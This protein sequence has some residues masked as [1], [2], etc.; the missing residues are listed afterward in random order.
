DQPG[1]KVAPDK[2]AQSRIEEMLKNATPEQKKA[3]DE[4][5]AAKLSSV[6]QGGDLQELR[7]FVATFGVQLSAGQEARLLL[8]ER[9]TS[10]NDPKLLLEVE[11]C[12]L[13]LHAIDNRQLAGQAVEALARHYARRGLLEDAASKYRT[14]GRDFAHIVI[15]DGKTG[16][17]FYNEMASDK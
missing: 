6:K 12:L 14:L 13:A 7:K 1:N 16:E 8:A 3:L 9:L 17:D 11:Q 2:H 5:T 10:E 15:R 4:K